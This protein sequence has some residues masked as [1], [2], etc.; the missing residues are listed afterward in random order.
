ML[1]KVGWFVRKL[2]CSESECLSRRNQV[3]SE[4]VHGKNLAAKWVVC[5]TCVEENKACNCH[6]RPEDLKSAVDGVEAEGNSSFAHAVINMIGMLIGLGQ[7]STPYALE[8]GGWTSA[9]LL[10]GLGIICAYSSHL[11]GKCL[12]KNPKS[13]SYAD[14]G[15]ESFGSKGRVLVLTFIYMEIFMALVSYTI[16]LHDNIITVFSG[17]RLSLPWLKLSKSQLLTMM[18]VLIALPSL[19]LRNLST[20]SLLSSGGILMSL[21]I[22]TSVAFT[23][24]FG[25]LKANHRI[26][27]LRLQ[28]IP[29]ISGLYIFSYAGH[30]VFPNLYKSMKDPSKFTKASIVSFASVTTLYTALAFMG[31]KLFGPEVSSQITLSMPRQLIVTKI[32]LWATVLTPMTKYALEF[33]PF[34]IQLE[35]SLPDSLSPRM[36]VVVR[37]VVGSILL[38]VILALALSVPYFEHVLGL[39]G[40]LVSVSIC[41]VF[42]CAFYTKICW[43][44]ISKPLLILNITLIAF[45]FILG[46]VGTISSSRLLI[47]TLIRAHST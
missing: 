45:G 4:S 12:D 47:A 43:P 9:F 10:I 36:K 13:R 8:N 33:A 24:V 30:I 32:A 1:A 22:F 29:A 38:I 39:T 19:W 5:E 42:P 18:A 23:A 25:G 46:T 14:I 40:S 17:T 15:Q 44:H 27:V 28:K 37:G 16:S 26:P 31:A 7:L 6:S 11:L 2:F 3:A 41:I 21:V 20:I 34:A 35:H